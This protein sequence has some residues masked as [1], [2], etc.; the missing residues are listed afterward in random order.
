M[1]YKTALLICDL[2][3]KT[4]KNLYD[5]ETIIENINNLIYM[6]EYLPKISK[7]IKSELYQK[8]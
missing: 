4:V 2:Q 3:K 5:R 7:T 1:T 8:N 6:K